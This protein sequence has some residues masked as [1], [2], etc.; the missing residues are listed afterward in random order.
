MNENAR[1]VDVAALLAEIEEEVDNMDHDCFVKDDPY[2]KG[3][4]D[5]L[6]WVKRKLASLPQLKLAGAAIVD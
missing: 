2:S 1:I 5:E 4:L 6:R 3:L